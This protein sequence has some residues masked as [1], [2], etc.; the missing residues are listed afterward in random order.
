MLV[1]HFAFSVC[2]HVAKIGRVREW[3]EVFRG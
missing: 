3:V 1:K 2:N